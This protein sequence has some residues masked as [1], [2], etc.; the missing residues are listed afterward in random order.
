MA[1]MKIKLIENLDQMSIYYS[2][3]Q[4]VNCECLRRMYVCTRQLYFNPATVGVV[5]V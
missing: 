5:Y 2:K 3:A 1:M 4:A